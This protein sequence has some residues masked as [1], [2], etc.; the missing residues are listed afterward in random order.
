M[1]ISALSRHQCLY[2]SHSS[3]LLWK[4]FSI[5]SSQLFVNTTWGMLL[6]VGMSMILQCTILLSNIILT[7]CT[8]L[9]VVGWYGESSDMIWLLQNTLEMQI[10][11]FCYSQDLCLYLLEQLMISQQPR[12]RGGRCWQRRQAHAHHVSQHRGQ[13]HWRGLCWRRPGPDT[14]RNNYRISNCSNL[15]N[16]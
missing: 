7:L 11:L 15:S 6:M 5:N 14:A 1:Y 12:L 3:I 4:I 10:S 8:V 9:E 13:S 16:N 2:W